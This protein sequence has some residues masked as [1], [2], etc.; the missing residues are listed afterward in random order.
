M[1][2]SRRKTLLKPRTSAKTGEILY[3]SE[4][5]EQVVF[6]SWFRQSFPD[7]KIFA[8]PN[9]GGRS[10]AEAGRLKAEGVT[11]GV[12]DLFIPAWRVWVEMKRQKKGVLS[13]DQKTM[14]EYLNGHGYT[15]LICRGCEAAIEAITKWRN[16]L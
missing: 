15:T 12:P 13:K 5:L 3:P 6:V 14:I 8:I 9:G 7:V 2:A 16:E 4:H 11:A 10:K 1:E